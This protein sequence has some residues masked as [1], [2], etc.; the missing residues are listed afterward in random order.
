MASTMTRVRGFLATGRADPTST[1]LLREQDAYIDRLLVQR[2]SLRSAL[3][4]L[5]EE[6]SAG[7]LVFRGTALP[8]DGEQV[9]AVRVVER[10]VRLPGR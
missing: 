10:N 3:R 5:V 6:D 4:V 9:A 8:L 2:G 1:V 7:R